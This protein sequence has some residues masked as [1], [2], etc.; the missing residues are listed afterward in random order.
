MVGRQFTKV[1]ES[2]LDRR[3]GCG[4]R[5]VAPGDRRGCSRFFVDGEEEG[6]Q[7]SGDEDYREECERQREARL[8]LP[9]TFL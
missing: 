7:E 1:V 5:I 9:E 8:G 3:L 6:G 4:E 2:G